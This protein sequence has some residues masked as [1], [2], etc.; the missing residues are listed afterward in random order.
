MSFW[1]DDFRVRD[2]GPA[3]MVVLGLDAAELRT[4]PDARVGRCAALRRTPCAAGK[5]SGCAGGFAEVGAAV[6][7]VSVG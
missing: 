1:G 3:T 2:F 5:R 7:T 4:S 6:K